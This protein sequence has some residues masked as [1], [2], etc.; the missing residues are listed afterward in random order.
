MRKYWCRS[1]F[2]QCHPSWNMTVEHARCVWWNET[3]FP[4]QDWKSSC[5]PEG[6]P[7]SARNLS[8]ASLN[9]VN[10]RKTVHCC[11]TESSLSEAEKK[12]SLLKEFLA[13]QWLWPSSTFFILLF[14]ACR[15]L[16]GLCFN[17]SCCTCFD[18]FPLFQGHLLCY[19][20]LNCPC[21]SSFPWYTVQLQS[22]SESV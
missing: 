18:C 5:Y 7:C 1:R 10:G 12:S 19:M 20:L 14:F 11:R 22:A 4:E 13:Q 6:N 3:L 21:K 17:S 2:K 9:S 8:M 15:V 16:R